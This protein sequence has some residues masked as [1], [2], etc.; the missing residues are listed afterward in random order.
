M[1]L[2]ANHVTLN[3]PL[4]TFCVL[5]P[6]LLNKYTTQSGPVLLPR[7]AV[8]ALTAPDALDFVCYAN[9]LRLGQ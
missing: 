9:Y 2:C 6:L 8:K 1:Q 3:K 5:S 4:L 7:S